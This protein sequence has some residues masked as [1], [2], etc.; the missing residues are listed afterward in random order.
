MHNII[1]IFLDGYGCYGAL[2]W[3]IEQKE[4]QFATTLHAEN[5]DHQALMTARM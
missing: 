4:S 5:K 1:L 3:M 2:Q